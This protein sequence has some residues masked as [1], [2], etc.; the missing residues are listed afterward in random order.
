M[1][2]T[3]LLVLGCTALLI[4]GCATAP[5]HCCAPASQPSGA[6]HTSYDPA[7]DVTTIEKGGY[8]WFLK[9]NVTNLVLTPKAA[10]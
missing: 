3:L 6:G 9:G 1:K 7:T 5:G 2:F 10:H 8:T 4:A